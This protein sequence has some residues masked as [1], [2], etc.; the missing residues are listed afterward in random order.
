M[1]S[2]IAIGLT[3]LGTCGG[4]AK[5][6]RGRTMNKII[7]GS[8]MLFG[9]ALAGPAVAA[10]IPLKAPAQPVASGW[11]GWYVGVEAGEKWK[12]DD[13]TTNCVEQSSA[14]LF[15]CG[16]KNNAVQFPH[17]PDGS[18]PH[19][20]KNHGFRIG[21]Y[22]G[23]NT[24]QGLWVYGFEADWAHYNQSSSVV[25]LVGATAL[26]CC[27]LGGLPGTTAAFD[28]TSVT[29]K[30]DASLRLRAGYLIIPDV[31]LY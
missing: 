26:N 10:D 24:Q 31:L 8:A 6:Q 28:R 3:A 25:G 23:A 21:G 4:G 9:L 18:S 14:P 2:I 30:W 13:W 15:A 29:N 20:F 7:F 1:R 19:D 22:L 16:S 12:S 5:G 11:G 17:A 27:G